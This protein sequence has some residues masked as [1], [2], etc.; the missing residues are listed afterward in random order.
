[1][2]AAKVWETPEWAALAAHAS[3]SASSFS[4]STLL[5]ER[6]LQCGFEGWTLDYSRQLVSA[7]T[8]SLLHALAARVNLTERIAAMACGQH[9]NTTEGRAVLHMALR[10]KATDSLVVDGRDVCADVRGV[11]GKIQ[12][13]VQGIRSGTHVGASGKPLRNIVSIGIGGS[14]LG[15]EFAYEALRTDP[16]AKAAAQGYTLRFLAN[17]DPIDI[18]RAFEVRARALGPLQCTL[19]C[20]SL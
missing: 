7:E 11:Q 2:A 13:F 9:I 5:S 14:Y 15:V 18:A 4:L 12:A 10:C 17:V 16:T 3:G 8:L 1:M 6:T 19:R 20:P